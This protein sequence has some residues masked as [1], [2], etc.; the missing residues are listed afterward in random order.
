MTGRR[1]SPLRRWKV[2]RICAWCA[3]VLLGVSVIC[4]TALPYA[5]DGPSEAAVSPAQTAPPTPTPAPPP[6]PVPMKRLEVAEQSETPAECLARMLYGEV[7][8]CTT[9]EQAAAVWCALNRVDAPDFPD[10]V[11]GVVT[12]PH[13]FQGYDPDHPVLPELLAVAEDVLARRSIEDGCLGSVG[14]VLPAEYLYFS[15]DG[16]HNYF[17]TDYIGGETWDWGLESPYEES[18]P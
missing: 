16:R 13:Q 12:Q 5:G 18:R 2:R 8:G 17:R 10:D 6:Q 15:G 7:R 11:V 1:L 9:T 14:R 3:A 4:M